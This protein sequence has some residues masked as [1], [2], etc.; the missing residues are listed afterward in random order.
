VRL[1][2]DAWPALRAYPWPG[3]VRELHAVLA[4]AALRAGGRAIRASDLDLPEPAPANA[5]SAAASLERQ[6]I[7]TA[8]RRAG[9]SVAGAASRIGWSRQKLYRRMAALAVA[10]RPEAVA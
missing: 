1:A 6:M 4:R 10:R 8:L 5:P 2:A 3:N 9:G 7:E